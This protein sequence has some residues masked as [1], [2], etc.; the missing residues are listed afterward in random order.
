MDPPSGLFATTSLS[1]RSSKLSSGPHLERVSFPN[2]PLLTLIARRGKSPDWKSENCEHLP[3]LP[4]SWPDTHEPYA[5]ALL[6]TLSEFFWTFSATSHFT[7]LS[8]TCRR[9]RSTTPLRRSSRMCSSRLFVNCPW[10]SCHPD[11]QL[12]ERLNPE[13]VSIVRVPNKFVPDTAC[14]DLTT[15]FPHPSPAGTLCAINHDYDLADNDD[16]NHDISDDDGDDDYGNNDCDSKT[17]PTTT[18]AMQ[19]KSVNCVKPK[20]S[21]HGTIPI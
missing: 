11:E 3:P 9:W 20:E 17:A 16:R 14:A 4:H 1:V 12:Y 15:P 19:S 2:P 5:S 21:I 10:L 6:L 13:L 18:T 8:R 7:V